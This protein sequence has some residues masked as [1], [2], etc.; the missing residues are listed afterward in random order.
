MTSISTLLVSLALLA[1]QS[2]SKYDPMTRILLKKGMAELG[3]Y[4]MLED[5]TTKVGHRMCGSEGDAKAVA[6]GKATMERLGFQNVRTM[7]CMV[8]HWVRGSVESCVAK[9]SGADPV[10]L[11]G[12]ALGGSI[13]VEGAALEAGVVEVRS[14]DECAKLGERAKGKIVFFNGAMPPE[15]LRTFASYGVAVQQRGGGAIAAAKVGAV[16][17]LVRSVSTMNDDEP[18]TGAMRYDPA[19]PKI[20]AMALGVQSAEKLSAMLRDDPDTKVA[21]KLSCETLPDAPSANVIGEIVGNEKPNEVIVVGGHL[22]SWD[23]GTGAH[24]DGAGVT[25]A[26]EA[27]RLIKEIGWQ[28]KRTIRVV[29]FANEEMG[30]R[31]ARAYA[32]YAKSAKEKH[33]AAIES[34]SGGFAPRAFGCSYDSNKLKRLN[35]WRAPLAAFGIDRLE[36]GSGG[37]ADVGPLGPLGAVLFGLEPESQRYFDYHHSNNDTLDKV[38]PRELELGALSLAALCWLIS[39]E[40]V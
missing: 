15:N 11:N 33:I 14:L 10:R 9:R 18:H 21:F 40:G 4:A 26:L 16:G 12:T 7:P 30:G 32:D 28:P 2:D 6:W 25:Q 19:V 13:G 35:K 23:K 1:P 38:N 20:P 36:P 24:D 37:G 5:L 27:L 8:P 34:D 39:E 31:G 3:A 22:D 17:V 29:L